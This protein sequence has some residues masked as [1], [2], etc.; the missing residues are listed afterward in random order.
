MVPNPPDSPV[1]ISSKDRA[2]LRRKSLLCKGGHAALMSRI[3]SPYVLS[4][5]FLH[6]RYFRP[7][8][9]HRSLDS[10]KLSETDTKTH[11]IR[12]MFGDHIICACWHWR[13]LKNLEQ[14]FA[15]KCPALLVLLCKCCRVG[16]G[17]RKGNYSRLAVQRSEEFLGIR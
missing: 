13:I 6:V 4:R 14:S 10:R 16:Q 3:G 12:V 15:C 7:L 5:P 11:I 2:D 17:F 1:H 8:V 9:S